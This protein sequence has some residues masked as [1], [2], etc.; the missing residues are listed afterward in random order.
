MTFAFVFGKLI[1]FT[2]S[3]DYVKTIDRPC[4]DV[5][6]KICT[7]NIVFTSSSNSN[8]SDESLNTSI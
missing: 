3:F 4:I 7:I 8:I 2:K 1:A 5:L 6:F